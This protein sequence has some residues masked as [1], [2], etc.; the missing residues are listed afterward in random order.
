MKKMKI[1]KGNSGITLVALIIT[2]IVLIILAGVTIS[3]VVGDNGIIT[4]SKEAKINM[5]NASSEEKEALQNMANEMNEIESGIGGNEPEKPD[6]PNIKEYHNGV[7]I[8]KGFYYV[9]GEAETGLVISDH[10]DDE[11][12]AVKAGQTGDITV[13]LKGNQFVWIPVNVEE[14]DTETDIKA[15]KRTKTYDGTITD[16]GTSCS[17][18]YKNITS[19]DETG[20]KAEYAEMY[21]SVYQ[22]KGFYVGRYEAGCETERTDSNKAIAQGQSNLVLMQKDKY[23]YN[24]VPWGASM[25]STAPASTV[26]GAVELSRGMYPKT[27][28]KYGVTSGL[29]YGVQWDAIMTFV[30]DAEHPVTGNSSSW[31]N[32]YHYTGEGTYEQGKLQ[33]TGTNENWKAKNMYDLAGNAIEWTNEANGTDYRFK[34]GGGCKGVESDLPASGREWNMCSPDYTGSDYRTFRPMLY[35]K[36]NTV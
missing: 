16:P 15:F 7:P 25:T 18:P 11:K 13:P 3:L 24:Y 32:Y 28:E 30:N 29:M 6:N 9:G 17:E 10:P 2:I 31:G 33:K 20:E 19:A 8:P 4:K 12:V 36:L 21:K 35:V 1:R 34:R 26:M 5:T 14:T 22:N 27:S 23:V